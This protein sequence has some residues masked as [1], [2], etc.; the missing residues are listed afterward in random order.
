[1]VRSL[2]RV[3]HGFDERG[4]DSASGRADG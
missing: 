2:Q 1:M 3:M 4:V